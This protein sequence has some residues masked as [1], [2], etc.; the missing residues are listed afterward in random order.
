MQARQIAQSI[1]GT[2]ADPL[3]VLRKMD[4]RLR[5]SSSKVAVVMQAP[6]ATEL[7]E[8]YGESHERASVSS[9]LLDPRATVRKEI[10]Q[11]VTVQGSTPETWQLYKYICSLCTML[12]E[13]I[14]S[15]RQRQSEVTGEP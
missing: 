11:D 12:K 10:L 8:W 4:S 2:S 5:A 14:V 7:S 1:H 15:H 6:R 13:A 3:T 9:T